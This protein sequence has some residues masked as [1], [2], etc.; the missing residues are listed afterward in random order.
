ME[1]KTIFQKLVENG[2]SEGQASELIYQYITQNL[3]EKA[4]EVRG[5]LPEAPEKEV[6]AKVLATVVKEKAVD[7]LSG[8]AFD[9]MAA[10]RVLACV[11]LWEAYIKEKT[12]RLTKEYIDERM[13]KIYS[14]FKVEKAPISEGYWETITSN[15]RTGK[16]P[17][18]PAISIRGPM[19]RTVD[20]YSQPV[21]EVAPRSYK[22]DKDDG[23]TDNLPD[24]FVKQVEDAL[25][26]RGRLK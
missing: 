20:G 9:Q 6:V 21:I 7:N 10:V 12:T 14:F 19:W 24:W 2:L 5:L 23:W 3:P 8:R 18:L 25:T 15:L 13:E 11:I 22:D 17:G 4:E 16:V 26:K 1:K